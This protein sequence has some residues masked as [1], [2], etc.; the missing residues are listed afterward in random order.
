MMTGS[1]LKG[2]TLLLQS[3]CAESYLKANL[4]LFMAT[5]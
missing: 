5:S 2:N 3:R 4:H 1:R